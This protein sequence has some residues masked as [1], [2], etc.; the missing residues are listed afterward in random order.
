MSNQKPKEKAVQF[1]GAL[2]RIRHDRGKL[3]ALRRGLSPGTV[4]D[5]WPVVADLGGS[6]GQPGESVFVDLAALYATQPE[7]SKAW[8]FGQTCRE[9]A[10]KDSKDY[11]LAES[12]ERRFRR[13]IACT[14]TADLLGQMRSWIRLAVNKT[15][16][17]NYESLFI[18]L[19]YWRWNAD[20]IRVNWARSFWQSEER[21]TA[22]QTEEAAA[23]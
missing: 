4:M 23:K 22:P 16:G 21:Q 20:D 1:V 6:I 12:Y 17:V 13:L 11:E 15:V 14:D 8:N 10:L 5:A 9:I 19:W 2:R 7:E 3:A 18:D